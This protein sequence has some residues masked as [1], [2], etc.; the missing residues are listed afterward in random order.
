M[1]CVIL[2]DITQRLPCPYNNIV[3]IATG[4]FQHLFL[5]S[6]RIMSTELLFFIG[7]GILALVT[8]FLGISNWVLLS[9]LSAKITNLDDDIEKKT[10]ELEAFKKE[11]QASD[12][13][14]FKTDQ[15]M[16]RTDQSG[17]PQPPSQQIEIVRN[18][19]GGGFENYDA[20]APSVPEQRS[21]VLDVVDE[22][23]TTARSNVVTL[24]LYSNAKKDTDFPA[25]WKQL[26]EI[27]PGT[28]APRIAI[29][30]GNVMFLYDR[31]LQYLKKFRD[32]VLQAG[33]TI[34]FVNCEAELVA[35]LSANPRLASCVSGQGAP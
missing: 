14:A 12:G 35:I 30:F 18:V 8:I 11:R 7:A 20:Q 22:A 5:N 13:Q 6:R 21:D 27:L 34:A 25:V 17:Y 24:S 16:E 3:Y 33:G 10:L 29:D 32:V 1:Y 2:P 23:A 19:R 15:S 31:E 26:S 4:L 28:P 9:S